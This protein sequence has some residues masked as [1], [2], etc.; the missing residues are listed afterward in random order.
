MFRAFVLPL[1]AAALL[2]VPAHQAAAGGGIEIGPSKPP[3]LQWFKPNLKVDSLKVFK[4]SGDVMQKVYAQAIVRNTGLLSTG[5]CGVSTYTYINGQLKVQHFWF[6]Q[7]LAPGQ[8]QVMTW[9]LPDQ[10]FNTTQKYV[11]YVYADP[12]NKVSES[13]EADNFAKATIY[14]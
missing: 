11:M 13:N 7:G 1:L 12:Y 2:L 6:T 4:G 9:K 8:S 3:I 5:P 10:Q 14:D